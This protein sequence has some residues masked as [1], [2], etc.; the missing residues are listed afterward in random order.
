MHY[1][2]NLIKRFLPIPLAIPILLHT[3]ILS[4][5]MYI[6]SLEKLL[7]PDLQKVYAKIPTLTIATTVSLLYLLM[8]ASYIILFIK[9]KTK[10]SPKFGVLWD[11]NKEPY[12]PSCKTLLS[13]SV[14]DFDFDKK[15]RLECMKCDDFLSLVNNGKEISLE[16][17]RALLNKT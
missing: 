17:A 11:N 4:G 7:S 15:I 12:C 3:I 14:I 16:E 8:V 5:M 6:G 1:L 2:T 9:Y 13:Q 10:L